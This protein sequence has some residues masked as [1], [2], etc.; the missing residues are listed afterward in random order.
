MVLE[1][2]AIEVSFWW[3]RPILGGFPKGVSQKGCPVVWS[4]GSPHILHYHAGDFEQLNNGCRRKGAGRTFTGRGPVR[5]SLDLS[6]HGRLRCQLRP[7]PPRDKDPSLLLF[8]FLCI[9][10]AASF[11]LD[12]E[13][14]PAFHELVR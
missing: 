14:L 4:E 7:D 8:R 2:F 5:R 9:F 10:L 3:R 11:Q 1:I 6:G 13:P 12:H